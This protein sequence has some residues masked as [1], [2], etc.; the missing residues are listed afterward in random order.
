MHGAT[1]EKRANNKTY[2]YYKCVNHETKGNSICSGL[3]RPAKQLDDFVVKTLTKRSEDRTFL[4]DRE[5]MLSA[6]KDEMRPSGRKDML[7]KLKKEERAIQSRVENLMEG[8]ESGLFEKQDFAKEYEKLKSRLRENRIGQEKLSDKVSLL[9]AAY[10]ALN[11]S[12]EQISS[13]GTNWEYLDDASRAA[14]ISLIVKDITVPEDNNLH[15][16]LFLDAKEASPK[17]SRR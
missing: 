15:F 4:Q 9:G 17:V 7:E 6:M 13:F 2:S 14:R 10:E 16:R 8:W 1:F 3:S 12:F 11:A 5:E